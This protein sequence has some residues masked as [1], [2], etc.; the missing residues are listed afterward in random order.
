M[1]KKIKELLK[2][3]IQELGKGIKYENTNKKGKIS[4]KG[5]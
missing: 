1:N 4:R 3:I 5:K 2:I